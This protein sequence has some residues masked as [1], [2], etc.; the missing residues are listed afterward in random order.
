[1]RRSILKVKSQDESLLWVYPHRSSKKCHESSNSGRSS[2]SSTATRS[3]GSIL[4]VKTQKE[5]CL[6]RYRE[7]TKPN[8]LPPSY[9]STTQ[10]DGSCTTTINPSIVDFGTVS[11]RSYARTL[12]DNPSCSG[13]APISIDWEYLPQHEVVKV[14]EYE[15]NRPS[16]SRRSK[17]LM[18]IPSESRI[19]ML[20]EECGVSFKSIADAIKEVQKVRSQRNQTVTQN[21]RKLLK[22]REIAKKTYQKFKKVTQREKEP[23]HIQNWKSRVQSV[24]VLEIEDFQ[25]EVQVHYDSEIIERQVSF[26]ITQRDYHH[27]TSLRDIYPTMA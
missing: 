24:N 6:L 22:A 27:E 12:G 23:L 5:S 8:M 17:P 14:D 25:S 10:D 16:S 26:D 11:I 20:R 13:G 3:G 18:K 15:K 4:K 7:S 21:N 9:A 1:M 2:S 19:Q